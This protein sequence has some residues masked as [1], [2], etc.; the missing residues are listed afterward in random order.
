M[1]H[2]EP[3]EGL[4]LGSGE[5]RNGTRE[6]TTTDAGIPVAGDAGDSRWQAGLYVMPLRWVMGWLFF[7]ALWRRVILENKLDPEGPGYVGDKINHFLPHALLIRPLLEWSLDHPRVLHV[8]L[9][10]FTLLEGLVGVALLLGLVTRLTGF[11]LAG[12][13]LGILLGAG[14]LGSTC[15]DEWQIGC[16]CVVSGVVFILAGG[17]PLSADAWLAGRVPRLT[18]GWVFPLLTSASSPPSRRGSRGLVVAA[19]LA[20]LA[21]TLWTNQV[22]YGG[23]WGP[24][25]NNSVKPHVVVSG[26]ALTRD[27]R[28]T[29]T[30]FRDQGPDTYGAFLVAVELVDPSGAV[31]HRWDAAALSAVTP[32]DIRNR[33]LVQVKAGS[34]G[35]V[36][37]LGGEAQ[38]GLPLPD[39]WK[40]H[41]PLTVVVYDVSGASWSAP[42]TAASP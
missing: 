14:W 32:A 8:G 28:L 24:L 21:L 5:G 7:S 26:A 15:V 2:T 27:G 13:S 30:V 20:C 37:P 33:W 9:W 31:A 3:D 40:P 35:L 1:L 29:F 34:H 17:G 25:H 38:V 12:L 19:G 6:P 39:D 42:V 41:F 22:F 11:L 4:V 18:R 10:F 16:L 23:V 36:V